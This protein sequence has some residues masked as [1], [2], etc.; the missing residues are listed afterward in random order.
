MLRYFAATQ[1]RNPCTRTAAVP[2]S[3]SSSTESPRPLEQSRSKAT[4]ALLADR[5]L[6]SARTF[7]GSVP[8]AHPMSTSTLTRHVVNWPA[9]PCWLAVTTQ[10]RK[11]RISVDAHGGVRTRSLIPASLQPTTGRSVLTVAW[12]S[13]ACRTHRSMLTVVGN[14]WMTGR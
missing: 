6:H 14:G 11:R 13:E 5:V 9:L 7:P 10:T 3:A 8:A 4:P 2:S 12:A 1:I